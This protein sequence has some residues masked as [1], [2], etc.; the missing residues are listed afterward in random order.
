M[1]LDG[2]EFLHRS[3][4]RIGTASFEH[5]TNLDAIESYIVIENEL[6]RAVAIDLVDHFG[7]RIVP[8]HKPTGAP[9]RDLLHVRPDYPLGFVPSG[10][11][12]LARV[13][14]CPTQCSNAGE[15]L[16]RRQHR[17][18]GNA[19]VHS[20]AT[21]QQRHEDTEFG[22]D[23]DV[24]G[25]TQRDDTPTPGKHF[26]RSWILRHLEV[27]LSAHQHQS[28]NVGI[29]AKRTSTTVSVFSVTDESSDN[30]TVERSP[31][32]VSNVPAAMRGCGSDSGSAGFGG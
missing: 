11:Q 1:G 20:H 10:N 25:R 26:E 6:P 12:L 31:I 21:F 3:E 18:G 15:I 30:A 9:A 22:V 19:V 24:E 14:D 7:Q 2:I 29:S 4:E 32:A 5:A 28:P 17:R 16:R 23:P 8:E 27:S 13:E